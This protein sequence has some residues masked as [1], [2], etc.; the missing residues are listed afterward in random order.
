ME[1]VMLRILRNSSGMTLLEILVA[2]VI[3]VI[4]TGAAVE[5]YLHQHKSWIIQ[6]GVSDLQQNGRAAIDEV[7]SKVRMAGYGVVPGLEAMISGQS[8]GTAE[9]DSIT[10]L[11]LRQPVCTTS[12]AVAMPQPSAELRCSGGVDC[13]EEGQW[14]YIWDPNTDDG[15]FFEISHVQPAAGHLQHNKAPL[16]KSY[17]AGSK[18]FTYEVVRY[19]IDDWSDTTHPVLMVQREDNSPD[20]FADDIANMQI[21]FVLSDKSVVERIPMA[22]Y[23]RQVNLEIVAR[24]NRSDLLLGDYRYDTLTTSVQVRNLAL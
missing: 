15:E 3:G 7:A 8:I 19:F 16:S 12:I 4:A 14:C 24:T 13:F 22:K 5:L 2:S 1:I 6:D 11:F 10:L 17:P 9:P 23:V 18:L 20:I 21:T